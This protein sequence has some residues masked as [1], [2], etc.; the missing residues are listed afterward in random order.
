MDGIN[1]VMDNTLA[2]AM[3]VPKCVVSFSP[4]R[5]T[6]GALVYGRDMIM[7]VPL[8]AKLTAICDGQQQMINKNLI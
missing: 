2:K 1:Q 4:I 3:H 5:T 7:D 6:P 8:I